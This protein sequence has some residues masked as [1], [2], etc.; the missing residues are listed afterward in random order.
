MEFLR[1]FLRRHF[2]GESV[3]A[4]RNVG[5]F[6]RLPLAWPE[7]GLICIAA[8]GYTYSWISVSLWGIASVLLKPLDALSEISTGP[9]G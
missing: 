5:C 4:L 7:Q 3:V 1:S 9:L 8:H 2:A 6:L